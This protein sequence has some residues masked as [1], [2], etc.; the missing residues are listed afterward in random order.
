[1]LVGRCAANYKAGLGMDYA[2]NAGAEVL[3]R[4]DFITEVR[5]VVDVTKAGR[6]IK[7][8]LSMD[9]ACTS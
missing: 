4:E 7:F 6:L 5:V 8:L 3:Q 2:I 9:F 1:M